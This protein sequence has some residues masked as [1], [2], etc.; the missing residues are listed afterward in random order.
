[1]E[2]LVHVLDEAIHPTSIDPEKVL[3]VRL[4]LRLNALIVFLPY[5]IF[6]I[7]INDGSIFG[8]NRLILATEPFNISQLLRLPGRPAEPIIRFLGFVSFQV[9]F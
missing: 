8:Y 2:I 7:G 4:C 3:R 9:T 5:Q 1:M 6:H